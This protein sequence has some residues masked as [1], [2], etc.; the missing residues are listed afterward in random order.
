MNILLNLNEDIYP[1][2]LVEHYRVLSEKYL[3]EARKLLKAGFSS[4]VGKVLGRIGTRGEEDRSKKGFEVGRT[5]WF[6][7]FNECTCNAER[8]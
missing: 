2:D 4:S 8:R 7:V 5:W 1:E 3:T 6:M